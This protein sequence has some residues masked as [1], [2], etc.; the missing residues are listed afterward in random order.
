MS[1][2]D[3]EFVIAN[4]Q[5][6][7]RPEGR[8]EEPDWAKH[9]IIPFA[10]PVRKPYAGPISS[11]GGPSAPAGSGTGS[12]GDRPSG[13]AGSGTAGPAG[14]IKSVWT[15]PKT[16]FQY[17]VFDKPANGPDADFSLEQKTRDLAMERAKSWETR[18][19][20]TDDYERP[21]IRPEEPMADDDG[22]DGPNGPEADPNPTAFETRL[23][24]KALRDARF[25]LSLGPMGETPFAQRDMDGIDVDAE[26]FR[27]PEGQYNRHGFNE[28]F[29]N[30]EP[31]EDALAHGIGRAAVKPRPEET[32]AGGRARNK[33]E[34]VHVAE[35]RTSIALKTVFRN[36]MG[37]TA[38]RSAPGSVHNISTKPEIDTLIRTVVD[39]GLD[40]A[41]TAPETMERPRNHDAV[42]VTVGRRALEGIS[43]FKSMPEVVNLSNN[44]RDNLVLSIGR[45]MLNL[46]VTA[47][48]QGDKGRHATSSEPV[49]NDVIKKKILACMDPSIVMK[50]LGPELAALAF[51]EDKT[52]S[53]HVRLP[54][55]EAR[56]KRIPENVPAPRER[57]EAAPRAFHGGSDGFSRFFGAESVGDLHE[58]LHVSRPEKPAAVDMN[59]M[60]AR[61]PDAASLRRDVDLWRRG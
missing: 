38:A 48:T 56:A 30:L 26:G 22:P 17:E 27:K 59:Y 15:D 46:A 29:R 12:G 57:V 33:P 35:D 8:T 50:A 28:L 55:G 32:T 10:P 14:P 23:R 51:R 47:P 9:N 11:R 37:G 7:G 1:R 3:P 39:S 53:S 19:G 20:D 13:P 21:V 31:N 6:F 42:A 4:R 25:E 5:E 58:E 41:W 18:R 44:E 54:E 36:M 52:P 34:H 49:V 2:N 60:S 24:E 45:A 40:K 61:V 43:A 16:G